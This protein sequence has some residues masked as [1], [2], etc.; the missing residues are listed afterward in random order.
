M[1]AAQR[2]GFFAEEICPVTLPQKKGDPVIVSQ[3]EHPRETSLEA[4]ARAAKNQKFLDPTPESMVVLNE[5]RSGAVALN[6]NR[7]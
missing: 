5:P 7:Q 3:D 4:L 1:L 6:R 2:S